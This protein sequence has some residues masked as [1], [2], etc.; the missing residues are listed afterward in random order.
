MSD[1]KVEMYHRPGCGFCYRAQALLQQKG[2]AYQ[3]YN[4]W[5]DERLHAE[6][7]ARTKGRTVPQILINDQPIGGCTE[8]MALERSGELDRLLGRA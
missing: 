2:V 5:S 8:L 4:I 7:M 1:V 3:G 6:M